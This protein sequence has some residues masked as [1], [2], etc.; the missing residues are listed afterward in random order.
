M[1]H[2]ELCTM[3]AKWL[4]R[5]GRTDKLTCPSVSVEPFS[6]NVSERPDVFGWNYWTTAMIECKVSRSDFLADAKKQFR[7]NPTDGIGEYRFYCC[8]YGVINESDIPD[9]WGLLWL[10]ENKIV[11]IRPAERQKANSRNEFHIL[12]SLMRKQG[13]NPQLFTN[14]VK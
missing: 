9:G 2:I 11:Q 10:V 8:P 4:R 7:T 5:G 3:A 1:T 14:E 6:P 12:A 13:L